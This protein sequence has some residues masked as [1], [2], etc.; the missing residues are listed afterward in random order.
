MNWVT[1]ANDALERRQVLVSKAQAVYADKSL[2]DA[3]KRSQVERINTDIEAVTDEARSLVEQGEAEAEVRSLAE[4]AG[5]SRLFTPDRASVGEGEVRMNTAFPE[6]RGFSDLAGKAASA[7]EF[8]EFVRSMVYEGRAASEGTDSAGGFL[9]P[10][11]Y[12]SGVLDLARNRAQTVNAGAVVVPL[13][14]DDVRV[15]KVNVDPVPG[16]RNEAAAIASGDITFGE[17]RFTARSLA[18]NVKAS[19]ELVADAENFGAVLQQSL[20]GAF[21]VRLDSAA[22]YGTGVAP[23]PLGLKGTAGVTATPLAANGAALTSWDPLVTAARDVRTANYDPTGMILA[24]RTAA[25]V[26]SFK[27]TAGQYLAAPEYLKDIPRYSSGNVPVNLSV[28]TSGAVCSDVF[29]GDFRNLMIGIRTGFSLKVLRER[30]ADTGEIGFIG[31]LRA[32]VQV[33]RAN[34]FQIVS[35]INGN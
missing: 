8:G 17:V 16:W 1:L 31:S 20:A 18:V 28:G 24:E 10:T 27:D 34:A 4:G 7:S 9:V 12:A 32:D 5:L 30:Y 11:K 33:A 29:V 23:E 19:E 2:S 6:G 22:L 15:A 26:A 14:S 3:E 35:G 21:A 25:K 13:G